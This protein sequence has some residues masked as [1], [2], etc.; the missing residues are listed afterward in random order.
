M[1]VVDLLRV[2]G[3][4]FAESTHSVPAE[5]AHGLYD[6]ARRNRMGLL[7]LTSLGDDDVPASLVEER[8]A[9]IEKSEATI[10]LIPR[11]ASILVDA[12][13]NYAFFKSIRPYP[14][15]TVDLDVIAFDGDLEPFGEAFAAA[16]FI[17][18]DEG[19]LSTTFRDPES[20]IGIDI[21]DEIGVSKI[22][23]LDKRNLLDHVVDVEVGGGTV[24]ALDPASDLLAII[25]HSIIKELM[26]V[27]S[28]YYTTLYT[29]DAMTPGEMDSLV[30]QAR[31]NRLI[32][33]A[34][35]HLGIT[36]TLHQMAHSSIPEKIVD[37]LEDLGGV[38]IGDD[39]RHTEMPMKFSAGSVWRVF[40]EKAGE[41]RMRRSLGVQALSLLNPSF[42]LSFI[43]KFIHQL[44]RETY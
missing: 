28:E 31:E 5:A 35:L 17:T 10:R 6:L 23:Y 26:Y 1:S 18:L 13:L 12:G 43:P 44:T 16:G 34:S 14:Y 42:A 20:G 40:F 7:L 22:V 41:P 38:R 9:M 11:V 24:R 33:A 30:T 37:L 3:S 25:S 39:D 21:Y 32:S 8:A 4:P 27:L 29:L 15:T 19:P 36:A 2:V